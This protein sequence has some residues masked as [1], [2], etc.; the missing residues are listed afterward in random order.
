M[1]ECLLEFMKLTKSG[2]ELVMLSPEYGN[3]AGRGGY[4][5]T[6]ENGAD[7]VADEDADADFRR[8]VNLDLRGPGENVEPEQLRIVQ[9]QGREMIKNVTLAAR[10]S[11]IAADQKDACAMNQ[12]TVHCHFVGN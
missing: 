9:R 1:N 8:G 10:Y 11:K 6:F 3:A 12:F 4:A 2:R 5:W 7:A